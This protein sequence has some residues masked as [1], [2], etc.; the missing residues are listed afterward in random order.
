MEP[1]NLPL[2]TFGNLTVGDCAIAGQANYLIRDQ[3]V[4][5][6]KILSISDGAAV[7]RYRKLQHANCLNPNPDKGLV[8]LDVLK[9]W[10]HNGWKLDG[11][12]YTIGAY[13][14]ISPTHHD[15]VR[16]RSYYL[17][18]G[19]TGVGLP[20][21]VKDEW[22]KQVPWAITTDNIASWGYHC[23]FTTRRITPIGP[24]IQSWGTYVQVTWEWY[25]KYVYE[26]WGIVPTKDAW[27]DPKADPIDEKALTIY[28]DSLN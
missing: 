22:Q 6:K 8:M 5:Q 9:D 13:G 28:L 27:L 16:F 20:N 17:F 23:I 21:S 2:S 10:Q 24:I 19:Y 25:D 12:T 1:Q 3:F 14:K 26:D 11:Y 4:Q 15:D 7:A 18:G